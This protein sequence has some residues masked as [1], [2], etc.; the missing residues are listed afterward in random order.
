MSPEEWKGP[1]FGSS[2][3]LCVTAF[4]FPADPPTVEVYT[5]HPEEFEKPNNL[6]CH[7]TNFYPPIITIDLLK[8]GKEIPNANQTELAFDGTWF[9]YLT[10]YVPI[11]PGKKDTY[12]C[13][14]THKE[15]AK[16]HTLVLGF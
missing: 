9:Y 13:R 12:A 6:I 7:V 14:V 2:A 5:S 15:T 10:K 4:P 3:C 1:I 11:T 8:N 16:V